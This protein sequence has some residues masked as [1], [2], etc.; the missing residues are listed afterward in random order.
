MDGNQQIFKAKIDS[1][2]KVKEQWF[3]VGDFVPEF[4]QKISKAIR[5]AL[6]LD[7]RSY[8]IGFRSTIIQKWLD[9][10]WIA[11]IINMWKGCFV[12]V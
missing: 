9:M 2:V 1:R 5:F 8:C 6:F 4:K 11:L 12:G 10:A 7:I 3:K